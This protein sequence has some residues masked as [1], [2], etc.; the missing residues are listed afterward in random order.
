MWLQLTL[1]MKVLECNGALGAGRQIVGPAPKL[2]RVPLI[3][4]HPTKFSTP[5]HPDK[6]PTRKSPNW[7]RTGDAA[8]G[9]VHAQP[10]LNALV[11]LSGADTTHTHKLGSCAH[12]HHHK[13]PNMNLRVAVPRR[14][15]R[16]LCVN[17]RR[18]RMNDLAG[19]VPKSDEVPRPRALQLPRSVVRCS[20]SASK[21]MHC[22]AL[23]CAVGCT[24]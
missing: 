17:A 23:T 21:F 9:T 22:F 8:G 7:H 2:H 19:V 20:N 1:P 5:P 3:Y 12:A 11:A 24:R 14:S 10:P 6:L 16:D 4:D 13:I 15:S 18:R